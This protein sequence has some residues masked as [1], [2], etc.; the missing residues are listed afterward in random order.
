MYDSKNITN[1]IPAIQIAAYGLKNA[2]IIII[3]TRIKNH[4]RPILLKI[5]IYFFGILFQFTTINYYILI[6]DHIKKLFLNKI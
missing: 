1:V 6:I 2:I 4:L 5:T 3:I